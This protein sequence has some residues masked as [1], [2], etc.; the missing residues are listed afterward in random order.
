MTGEPVRTHV[1]EDA[2]AGAWMARASEDLVA[3]SVLFDRGL[4]SHAAFHAQQAAEKALKGLVIARGGG[5]ARTHDLD[6]LARDGK[7]PQP[8][9][10]AAA[11]LTGFYTASRYPDVPGGVTA[12]D[13]EEA[14]QRAKEVHA[15]CQKQ[16]S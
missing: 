10:D 6:R 1:A 15:W 11:F 7:A 3:A 16:T 12:S 2:T 14:I 13:A 5:L 8:V 9:A 4:F